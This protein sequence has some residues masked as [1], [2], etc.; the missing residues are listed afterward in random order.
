[1]AVQRAQSGAS[2][3]TIWIVVFALLFAIALGLAILFYQQSATAAEDLA[4]AEQTVSDFVGSQ[5]VRDNPTVVQTRER[6]QE[7]NRAVLEQLAVDMEWVKSQ[8]VGDSSI[9]FTALQR[10]LE[11][12]GVTEGQ[13]VVGVFAQLQR[14]LSNAQDQI[15]ELE[16]QLAASEQ[17]LNRLGQQYQQLQQ[18]RQQQMAELANQVDQLRSDYQAYQEQVRQQRQQLSQRMEQV[19]EETQQQIRERDNRLKQLQDQLAAREQRIQDLREMMQQETPEAP[20]LA[21]QADGRI[22]SVNNQENLVYINRGQE[23][24]L[25]LGMTFEVFDSQRGVEADDEGQL[26]GKATV[27]VVDIS[28]KSAV[29]RIIRS[30]LAEAVVDG[31]I[32]AN[33][34]YDPNR[35]FKFYVFGNFDLDGDGNY[36]IAD[37]DTLVQLIQRW[38]GEVVDPQ[39]RRNRLASTLGEEVANQNVLPVDTDFVVIGR[40]PAAPENVSSGDRDPERI[41]RSIEA[42][43]QWEQYNRIL[44][45]AKTFSIPVLNHN[46]FLALIGHSPE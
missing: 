46:R 16:D 32:V 14:N 41:R 40:E 8:L 44:Q 45:E 12:H 27:E 9:R 13:T 19:R 3:A 34:V 35:T 31:D 26:R 21:N 33:A 39:A 20:N 6:A 37:R 2:P 28:A 23:D 5:S 29:C 7:N 15:G 30:S 10:Q 25:V 38:G 18:Q 36:T 11:E 4:S 1:M 17:R 24:H 22:I 43:E 42:R